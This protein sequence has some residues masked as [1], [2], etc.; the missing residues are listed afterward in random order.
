M[1]MGFP[2]FI[3]RRILA[4]PERQDRLSRPI[5]LIAVLGIIIGMAVMIV[6]VGITSGFQ[7][8]IKG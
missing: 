2:H 5:V 8:E 6:T 4:D 3:A 7:R 1:P